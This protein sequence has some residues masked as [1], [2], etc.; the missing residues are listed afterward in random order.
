LGENSFSLY[1]DVLIIGL[2]EEEEEGRDKRNFSII[3]SAA[4]PGKISPSMTC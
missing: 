1:H 2:E 4:I 3:C